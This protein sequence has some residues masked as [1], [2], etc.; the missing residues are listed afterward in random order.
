MT[1]QVDRQT[2]TV[3]VGGP[4]NSTDAKTNASETENRA[5]I[6]G[7]LIENDPVK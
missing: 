3:P 1:K 6:D 5:S 7:T 2:I 4:N